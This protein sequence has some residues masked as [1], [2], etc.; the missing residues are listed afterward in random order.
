MIDLIE[1]RKQDIAALCMRCRVRRLE[2]F[3]SAIDETG[4][5]PS[6]SDIDFLVEFEEGQDSDAFDTFF[7]LKEG[8]ENILA[9][10]ID[11]IVDRALKNPYVRAQIEAN[12][13]PVYGA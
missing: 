3:G 5:D 13:E 9:R 12:S 10:P 11:L 1:K 2:L 7:S 4:F 8:L 6:R